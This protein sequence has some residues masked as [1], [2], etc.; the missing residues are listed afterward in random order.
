MSLSIP[1]QSITVPPVAEA[2]A[3]ALPI[4][5]DRPSLA[6]VQPDRDKIQKSEIIEK[7]QFLIVLLFSDVYFN[8]V[9]LTLPS[10]TAKSIS[11]D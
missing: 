4:A 9:R 10:T 7:D 3:F 11:F 5:L 2:N 1:L 6:D 8:I